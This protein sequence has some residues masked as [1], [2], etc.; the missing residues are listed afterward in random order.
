MSSDRQ[1]LLCGL[2]GQ[3]VVLAG[4]LLERDN[5]RLRRILVDSAADTVVL[6]E[7][8]CARRREL[9]LPDWRNRIP[10]GLQLL[11][12]DSRLLGRTDLQN[13]RAVADW[14]AS[15]HSTGYF[16]RHGFGFC[17]LHG[18]Q[19]VSLCT[20]PFVAGRQVE[21]CIRTDP[22]YRSKGF[23]TTTALAFIEHCLFNDLLPHWE[24]P[25]DHVASCALAARLGFAN[26]SDYLVY[27]WQT[28]SA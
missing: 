12:V 24:C 28:S 18:Q 7:V 21:L 16:L 20:S 10:D 1:I 25:W 5:P 22:H 11:P 17:L 9:R 3:G 2:G 19:I 23:A 8:V 15:W 6:G 4:S 13:Y 27:Y 26:P 14:V